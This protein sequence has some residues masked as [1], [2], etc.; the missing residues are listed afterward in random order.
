MFLYMLV[1]SFPAQS[2]PVQFQIQFE[3]QE[4]LCFGEANEENESDRRNLSAAGQEMPRA[5]CPDIDCSASSAEGSDWA[6]EE[7]A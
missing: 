4:S 1:G 7:A 3:L 2:L 5:R 6:C